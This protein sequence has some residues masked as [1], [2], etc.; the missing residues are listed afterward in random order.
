[1]ACS[2]IENKYKNFNRFWIF[3]IEINSDEAT[4]APPKVPSANPKYL[5]FIFK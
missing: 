5:A 4:I 1:M 3:N 2:S